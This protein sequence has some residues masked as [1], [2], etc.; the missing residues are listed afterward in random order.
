MRDKII[1]ILILLFSFNISNHAI[2]TLQVKEIGPGVLYLKLADPLRPLS[3]DVLKVDL[4]N[5]NNYVDVLIPHDTLGV[6]GL[7][8]SQMSKYFSKQGKNIIAGV[9]GDFF[10][11]EPIQIQNS[12]FVSG[13]LI[14]GRN[15]NRS[16]LMIDENKIPSIDRFKFGGIINIGEKIYKLSSFNDINPKTEI[17]LVSNKFKNFVEDFHPYK[18]EIRLVSEFDINKEMKFEIVRDNDSSINNYFL[19]SKH[20]LNEFKS[21]NEF[22]IKLSFDGIE[23]KPFL[24]IG[25]LPGLFKNSR[26]THD[27]YGVENLRSEK[28]IS[29]N[30][31]TA[32]GFNELKDTLTLV[33]V[34]GRRPNHSMGMNLYELSRLMKMLGCTDAINLD[35]GGSSTMVIR[36]SVINKPSDFTGERVIYN[37]LMILSKNINEKSLNVEPKFKEIMSNNT[38]DFDIKVVDEWGY[39]TQLDSSKIKLSVEGLEGRIKNQYEFFPK[40]QGM[41]DLIWQYGNLT[42]TT[43]VVVIPGE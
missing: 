11:G 6:G 36:D 26:L 22:T 14:K 31:R 39:E 25:G 10:G 7:T 38:I 27:F 17:A 9:N 30:P 35:G 37:S 5:D 40:T 21:T 42:D 24:M 1:K 15:L 41:A 23:N 2:D 4:K 43:K 20:S 29:K 28:F 33:V 8:L 32:A 13:E 19:F 18:Y 12:S 34:D 3:I 16:I